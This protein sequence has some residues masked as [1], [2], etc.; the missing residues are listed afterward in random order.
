[1]NDQLKTA[2]TEAAEKPFV[3]KDDKCDTD[4]FA[5]DLC[6][7]KE[8]L[9]AGSKEPYSLHKRVLAL[10]MT[11]LKDLAEWTFYG[12]YPRYYPD[13]EL[14]NMN[15]K[16]GLRA[17]ISTRAGQLWSTAPEKA[18]EI[19]AMFPAE[20]EFFARAVFQSGVTSSQ[21]AIKDALGL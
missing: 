14:T 17:W 1:M 16:T 12:E 9:S 10:D 19:A 4:R 6:L 18:E 13:G 5:S 8:A 11:S 7:L 21:K 15:M 20:L 2:L 3:T